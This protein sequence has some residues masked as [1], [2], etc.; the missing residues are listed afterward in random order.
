MGE[1]FDVIGFDLAETHTRS[2][3]IIDFCRI[4]PFTIFEQFF[5]VDH[6]EAIYCNFISNFF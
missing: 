2:E 4:N 6:F 5:V 1:S 3:S